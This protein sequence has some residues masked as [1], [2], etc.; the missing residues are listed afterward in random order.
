MRRAFTFFFL[1]ARSS[2][3][4]FE[5]YERARTK[6]VS[7][8]A[9]AS[10][11]RF[12]A[13]AGAGGVV[14]GREPRVAAAPSMLRVPAAALRARHRRLVR[15]SDLGLPRACA[16]KSLSRESEEEAARAVRHLARAGRARAASNGSI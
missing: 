1:L 7:T 2:R 8:L 15:E 6:A 3:R 4:I 5:P 13:G 9:H 11:A 14:F 10:L 16:A 12:Q